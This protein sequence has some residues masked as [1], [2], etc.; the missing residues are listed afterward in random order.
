MLLGK[1]QHAV[2]TRPALTRMALR[3]I[4]D[5]NWNIKVRDIGPMNISIRKNRSYWLRDPV[6][7]EYFVLGSLQR[8]VRPGDTVFDA[9]ANIGLHVRFLVQIFGANKVVA[10]E[11]MSQNLAVLRKNIRLGYCEKHVQLV[12]AALADFDGE[13]E[14]QIDNVSSA[15]G[16]L[17]VITHGEPCYARKYY[18]FGPL[19]ER[20]TVARIDT[21]VDRGE[22][23]IPT[24]IKV[25]VEGAEARL[26]RGAA[27]TLVTHAPNLVIEL[28][29]PEVAR[30]VVRFLL[31]IGYHVFGHLNLNGSQSYKEIKAADIG[32]ITGLYS[33]QRCVAGRNRELIETHSD[34]VRPSKPA[35]MSD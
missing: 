3:A 35:G 1:L 10:F 13:D 14:F 24:L 27:R 16:T 5:I 26:L 33:L 17:N 6:E 18:G 28:H 29:G 2:R 21:L 7:S 30:A 15:S 32:A 4:P 34:Y 25:D 22:V 12:Q 11:P 8:L 19:T 20:V 9:G 31:E 23:P